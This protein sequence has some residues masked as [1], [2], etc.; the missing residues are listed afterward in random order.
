MALQCLEQIETVLL[1][2]G[3]IEFG[4]VRL[5]R[6]DLD[7]L[8]LEFLETIETG[9]CAPDR[10]AICRLETIKMGYLSARWI[11]FGRA[12]SLL[13]KHGQDRLA[14]VQREMIWLS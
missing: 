12:S 11:R 2:T 7:G 1:S 6:R 4:W 9:G 14:L 13:A 8:M 10:L 3:W 5:A